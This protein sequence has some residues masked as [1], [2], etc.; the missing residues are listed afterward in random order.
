MKVYVNI[1][2]KLSYNVAII[3]A[4]T[5]QYYND[6]IMRGVNYTISVLGE[7]IIGNGTANSIM[8]CKK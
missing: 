6:T 7:N 3:P 1:S 4:D 2:T 5:T 8:I